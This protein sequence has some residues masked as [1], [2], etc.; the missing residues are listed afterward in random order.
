[1][2]LHYKGAVNGTENAVFNLIDLIGRSTCS[3]YSKDVLHSLLVQQ[4]VY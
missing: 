4:Q 3:I 2:S 1:M